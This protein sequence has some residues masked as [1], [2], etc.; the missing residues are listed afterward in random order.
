MNSKVT[1]KQKD[2]IWEKVR[3]KFWEKRSFLE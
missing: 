3:R 1:D 2:D